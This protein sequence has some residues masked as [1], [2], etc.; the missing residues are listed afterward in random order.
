MEQT[1][2]NRAG[3]L[4]AL[5]AGLVVLL[6]AVLA[7]LA[8][9]QS[10]R[11]TPDP[12]AARPSESPSGS[13]ADGSRISD[14]FPLLAGYP[15]HRAESADGGLHGPDRTLSPIVLEACGRRVEPGSPTDLLRGGWTDVEDF[16]QRQLTTYV[17]DEAAQAYVEAILDAYRACPREDTSDG[18]A[19]VN[20][21][22][23]NGLG[24]AG[25]VA[26]TR[27][28]QDGHPAIGHTLVSVV[29]VGT[30]VL[31]A[32]TSNEG[33]GGPDV[34]RQLS[35][36]A[37]ASGVEIEDVVAAMCVFADAA[38]EATDCEA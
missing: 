36:A 31:L 14:D 9:R 25:V 37:S 19:S 21:L 17:D 12:A 38:E 24:D 4:V 29:R 28:E 35:A 13:T 7:A 15:T 5:G 18:Y 11:P 8:T 16:R 3:A 30:A 20:T 32:A 27:Y 2:S 23:Q 1:P 22:I 33:G 6:V 26:A 34:E 10:D